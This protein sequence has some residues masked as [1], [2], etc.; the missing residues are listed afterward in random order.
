M[1]MWSVMCLMKFLL[2][3]HLQIVKEDIKH[4]NTK[5]LT[6]SPNQ[7]QYFR[8]QTFIYLLYFH[9]GCY[10]GIKFGDFPSL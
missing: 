1:P 6:E 5:C 10:S 2:E 7:K 8:Q 3:K 9:W 4:M